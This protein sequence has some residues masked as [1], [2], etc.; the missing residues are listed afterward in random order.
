MSI[1]YTFLIFPGQTCS[2]IR[3]DTNMS[4]LLQWYVKRKLF[5][6]INLKSFRNTITFHKL[7]R[8]S[9]AKSIYLF[10][11]HSLT[12][13]LIYLDSPK[14]FASNNPLW[15]WVQQAL[16]NEWLNSE[17]PR[18]PIVT[19]AKDVAALIPLF[20]VSLTQ[21]RMC[22]NCCAQYNGWLL[23]FLLHSGF[24]DVCKQPADNPASPLNLYMALKFHSE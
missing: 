15:E 3:V 21:Q 17:K 23:G 18:V 19:L 13:Y 14:Q 22:F 20:P 8:C 24:Q 1:L 9:A 7:Q 4:Y 2:E 11:P 5:I 16:Y 12:C 10:I 6:F